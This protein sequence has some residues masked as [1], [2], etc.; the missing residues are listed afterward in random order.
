MKQELGK[1][2]ITFGIVFKVLKIEADQNLKC[3]KSTTQAID[4]LFCK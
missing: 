4:L 3:Q 1:Q 2:N